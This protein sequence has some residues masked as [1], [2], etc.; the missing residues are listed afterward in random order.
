MQSMG[1]VLADLNFLVDSKQI[2]LRGAIPASIL[3]HPRLSAMTCTDDLAVVQWKHPIESRAE[4]S[5][6]LTAST[7][8]VFNSAQQRSPEEDQAPV[9]FPSI[10][11]TA[12][13]T[14]VVD[15]Y[16]LAG[17]RTRVGAGAR[18]APRLPSKATGLHHGALMF[19]LDPTNSSQYRPSLLPTPSASTS[20][21]PGPSPNPDSSPNRKNAATIT[22]Y[23]AAS[24]PADTAPGEEA[25]QVE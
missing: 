17:S 19:I 16:G 25:E 9:S 4:Q 3:K 12:S 1:H 10:A 5:S 24:T 22:D 21:Q 18:A 2:V 8:K 11:P 6:R 23:L 7:H 14:A 15:G 20:P 13:G